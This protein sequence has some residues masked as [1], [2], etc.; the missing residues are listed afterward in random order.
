M[1][2]KGSTSK[3][4]TLVELAI[5]LVI[6]GL[7]LGAMLKAQELIKN[8]KTKRLYSQYNEVVASIHTYYDK[9]GVFPGDDPNAAN[10]WNNT[11]SGNGNGI[12][13]NLSTT[14]TDAST[15]ES[16]LAWE[17]LRLAN[18]LTG[19]GKNAPRNPYG[20]GVGIGQATVQGLT[21]HWIAFDTIPGEVCEYIDRQY[22][23]GV[24]ATGTIRGDDDYT[25]DPNT[26]YT[27]Y[28]RL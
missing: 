17:H 5:V 6:I 16:C 3:G 27:L 23:D 13:E 20:G 10:R 15:N 2:Q 8:A 21:T 19:S 22:D 25:A 4:F 26:T 28:I 11:S 12:I 9:Y 18:I 7:I 14:C 24:A 1:K